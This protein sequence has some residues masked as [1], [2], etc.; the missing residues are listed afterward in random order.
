[1]AASPSPPS[2]QSALSPMPEQK[3]PGTPIPIAGKTP[4]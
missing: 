4:P 2:G 1:L 3:P